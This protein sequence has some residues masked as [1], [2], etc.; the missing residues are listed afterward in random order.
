[1][2]P[3]TII[4]RVGGNE[5]ARACAYL[6]ALPKD[7]PW[8]VVVSE[9]RPQRSDN[10][11]GYLWATYQ[12]ILDRGGE[13]LGGWTKDDLHEFFLIE[14]FGHE[15]IEGFG[16]KRLKP[17]RRSSKLNKQEFS[18]FISFIQRRCAEI[19][20]FVADPGQGDN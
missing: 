15:V 14:H 17:L 1:M 7:K 5:V 8:R 20:I 4:L 18:D 10:Q 12:D 19:G 3:Q 16:R 6:T 13:M 9:Y 2:I 11:N